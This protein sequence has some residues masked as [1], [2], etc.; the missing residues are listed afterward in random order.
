MRLASISSSNIHPLLSAVRAPYA[1][2]LTVSGNLR[3]KRMKWHCLMRLAEDGAPPRKANH[4]GYCALCMAQRLTLMRIWKAI[5]RATL[6][7]ATERRSSRAFK[8][9]CSI[10][11]WTKFCSPMGGLKTQKTNRFSFGM[12][13]TK[14]VNGKQWPMPLETLFAKDK[15]LK[16]SDILVATPD[17]TAA[18][19]N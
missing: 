12:P 15:M 3:Q 5:V 10:T 9:V 14:P 8:I 18:A 11:E 17:V 7:N 16:P 1:P 2:I 4:L 6:L 13:R 19:F